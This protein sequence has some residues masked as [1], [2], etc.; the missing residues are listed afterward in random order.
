MEDVELDVI[1]EKSNIYVKEVLNS[2][3]KQKRK[4]KDDDSELTGTQEDQSTKKYSSDDYL[5]IETISEP[6]KYKNWKTVYDQGKSK[7]LF[8]SYT[9][10]NTLKSS[11]YQAKKR[12]NKKK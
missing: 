7:G 9:S 3:K 1:I 8:Q 10:S 4:F 11:Y 5:F 6:G 12:I 2:I